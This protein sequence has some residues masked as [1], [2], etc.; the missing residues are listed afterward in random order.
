MAR[1]NLKYAGARAVQ[2]L[3]TVALLLTALKFFHMEVIAIEVS[4]MAENPEILETKASDYTKLSIFF[5]L[6]AVLAFSN[7]GYLSRRFRHPNTRP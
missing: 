6:L 5:L 3:L 7:L 1:V 4:F 2:W